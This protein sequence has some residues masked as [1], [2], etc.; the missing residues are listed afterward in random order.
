[1]RIN[2]IDQIIVQYMVITCRGVSVS[3]IG[4]PSNLNLRE[5]IL[6]PYFKQ[7]IYN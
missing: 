1:M 3:V 6:T 7:I 2:L 5:P 4:L